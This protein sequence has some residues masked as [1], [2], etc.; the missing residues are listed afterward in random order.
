MINLEKKLTVI[1]KQMGVNFT[2]KGSSAALKEVFSDTGLLPG[3][4][5]RADQLA[6]LCLGYGLGATYEDVEGALLGVKVNFDEF[7]PDSLR[8]LCIVDVLNELV[9]SS[10][11]RGEVP[12]D[13]LMYD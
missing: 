8:L 3:L 9:K 7:T 11:T 5:K 6:Q 10:P 2:L 4:T 1:V 13:E 12:L